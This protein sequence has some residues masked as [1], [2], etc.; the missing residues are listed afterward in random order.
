MFDKLKFRTRFKA[1]TRQKVLGAGHG[2]QGAGRRARVSEFQYFSVQ[3]KTKVEERSEKPERSEARRSQIP[4]MRGQKALSTERRAQG[5][6]QK[7]KV[8]R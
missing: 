4:P 8:S 3:I 1:E 2:A 7:T 6:R 5:R